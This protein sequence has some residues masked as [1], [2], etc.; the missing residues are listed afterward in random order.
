MITTR[1]EPPV[2]DMSFETTVTVDTKANMLE[3][4]EIWGLQ[5]PK[6]WRKDDIAYAM[7]HYLKNET[8]YIWDNLGQE[9]ID[10]IGNIVEAGKGHCITVPHNPEHFNRLQKSLLVIGA[11]DDKK[12]VCRLY[13]LDEVYDIFKKLTDGHLKMLTDLTE[14]YAQD[15]IKEINAAGKASDEQLPI[16]FLPA[17]TQNPPEMPEKGQ[18]FACKLIRP[19]VMEVTLRLSAERYMVS[20]FL[21]QDGYIH[22]VCNWGN[23]LDFV[24]NGVEHPFP[25]ADYHEVKR[26][27]RK[28]YPVIASA[29]GQKVDNS[30]RCLPEPY[31]TTIGFEH[32]SK[33]WFISYK[34]YDK[35]FT[36]LAL[37]GP[38]VDNEYATAL[39][40]LRELCI[41]FFKEIMRSDAKKPKALMEEY[42]GFDTLPVDEDFEGFGICMVPMDMEDKEEQVFEIPQG[43]SM[44]DIKA[45]IEKLYREK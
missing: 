27:F 31:I 34:I 35:E 2:L 37:F 1:V 33:T 36:D 22:A 32:Q 26:P 45:A 10:M 38:M 28:K 16:H 30:N 4:A 17:L 13:M 43:M 6:N 41:K 39:G 44:E 11:N 14:K 40:N 9:A 20:Y 29:F 21:M 42:F 15:K 25:G 12:G 5:V 18:M 8:Q 23:V 24:W 3:A 7:N 19:R